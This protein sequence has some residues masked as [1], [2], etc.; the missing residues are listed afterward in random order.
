MK[1]S[2]TLIYCFAQVSTAQRVSLDRDLRA[3]GLFGGQVFVLFELWEKG[4]QSQSVLAR[5]L[6]LSPPTV[7][8]MVRSLEDAGFVSIGRS[9]TDGRIAIVQLTRKGHE[10]RPHVEAVWDQ[11]EE[12]FAGNL[13]PAER[14]MLIQLVEKLGEGLAAGDDD[15]A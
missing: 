13:T 3:I 10:V 5:S 14:L 11:A 4:G 9:S 8:K 1:F 7:N 2:D 15:E 12:R 6:R